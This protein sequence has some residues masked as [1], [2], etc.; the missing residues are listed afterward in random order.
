MRKMLFLTACILFSIQGFSQRF[1]EGGFGDASGSSGGANSQFDFFTRTIDLNQKALAFGLTETEFAAIKDDAY[2]NPNFMVGNIYQDETLLKSNI[3]MRYNAYAD[4]IEIKNHVSEKNYG[5][6]MKDPSIYTKINKD[7]YV[8]IPYDGSNE[9]GGYFNIL[10]DG[11]T[12]DL[13]KKTTAVFKKPEKAK[14]SYD[15]NTPPSFEKTIKYYLVENGRFLEL[16]TSKSKVLKAMD[17]KKPE[18]KGYIKD[19]NL[20][21][22]KEAD[23]VKVITYFDSLL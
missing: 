17:S 12:Y 20:D 15:S 10:S 7:I 11:K 18:V 2:V 16:P 19:N 8:F 22:A 6:L 1:G 9:K 21:V 13:Y 4:E 3:P 23:L 5:A 14:T